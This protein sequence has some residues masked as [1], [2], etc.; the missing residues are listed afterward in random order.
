MCSCSFVA[1]WIGRRATS[2]DD[3]ASILSWTLTVCISLS[4]LSILSPCYRE[5]TEAQVLKRWGW[6]FNRHVW[7]WAL[8]GI[9]G[10]KMGWS[11]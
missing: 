4:I 2:S 8:G 9:L 1:M 3:G 5:E 7:G 10:E 11:P 6:D